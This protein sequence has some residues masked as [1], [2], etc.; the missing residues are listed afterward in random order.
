LHY[1][2]GRHISDNGRDFAEML[3]CLI[4]NWPVGV[5][6]LVILGHSMGGLVARSAAHY[7][8]EA[9]H[10]W[11]ATLQKIVFLG[12]PHHG[13]PVERAGH[14]IDLALGITRY[15]APFA[16]LGKMRSS[17]IT[18]LR[19]GSIL[20]SDWAEKDRFAQAHDTRSPARL[21]GQTSCF[22]VAA[23]ASGASSADPEELRSDGLVPVASALG[24]HAIPDFDLGVKPENRF[25]AHQTGHLALPGSAAVAEKVHQ[26]L[27]DPE[28]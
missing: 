25:V 4:A 16:R 21:P 22:A 14:G 13:S 24:L 9:G 7:G 18:D 2:T 19:H 17:G 15:S 23:S 20:S 10:A 5:E 28:S 26:W 1:N 12:T 8:L 27:Q 6:Q 11:P 3:E